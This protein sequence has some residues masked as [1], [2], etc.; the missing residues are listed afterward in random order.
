MPEV[1]GDAALLVNPLSLEE[2]VNAME[3]I[4]TDEPLRTKLIQLGAERNRVF[5]WDKSAQ[6]FWDVILKF[7]K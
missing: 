3:T 4:A 5:S 1:A 6:Q 7:C 2:I